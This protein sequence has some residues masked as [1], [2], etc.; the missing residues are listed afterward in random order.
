[1]VE[2]KRPFIDR[3][4]KAVREDHG[5]IIGL[6]NMEAMFE[7]FAIKEGECQIEIALRM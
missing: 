7:D 3:E 5:V 6:P 2:G 4:W 1:M